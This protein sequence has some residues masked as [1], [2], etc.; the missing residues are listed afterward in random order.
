MSINLGPL[1]P[2]PS[3]GEKTQLRTAIGAADAAT[4]TGTNTGD[5]TQASILAALEGDQAGRIDAALLPD[6]LSGEVDPD[7]PTATLVIADVDGEWSITDSSAAGVA[8]SGP[9]YA[10]PELKAED[11]L[12]RVNAS[13][14][15]GFTAARSGATLTLTSKA[16]A[17]YY[18]YPQTYSAVVNF[19]ALAASHIGQR[20]RNTVTGAWWRATAIGVNSAWAEDAAVNTASVTA[21]GAVMASEIADLAAVGSFDPGDYAA[22]ILPGPY[23]DDA[24]AAGA[25]PAIPVGKLYRVTGGTI[26][27]RQA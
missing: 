2:A 22:A 19:A 25:T 24:A 4:N 17:E 12:S 18:K 15:I 27:W 26:A 8:V 11:I 7:T 16:G 1:G 20:Y 5:E 23:A 10:T 9:D 21:A 14:P 13:G 6:A 3:A